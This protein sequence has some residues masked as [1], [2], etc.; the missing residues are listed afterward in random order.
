MSSNRRS[1]RI[2]SHT[3]IC[4]GVTSEDECFIGHHV[5]FS[6]D[7]FPAAV[8]FDGILQ[9]VE[10]RVC[11]YTSVGSR[12]IILCDVTIGE[13]AL[14]GTG[15][16]VT[17]DVPPHTIVADNPSRELRQIQGRTSKAR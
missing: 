7:R 11:K 12:A 10:T 1:Q 3:F 17:K 16:I 13:G 14:V 5:M 4:E 2:A 8:N 15:S 9:A 6:N